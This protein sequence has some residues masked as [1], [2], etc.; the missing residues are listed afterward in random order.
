L[1]TTAT[2]PFACH[3]HQNTQQ[4]ALSGLTDRAGGTVTPRGVA[5]I[6]GIAAGAN[7][8]LLLHR[9]GQLYSWGLGVSGRLGLDVAIGGH[10]QVR[11]A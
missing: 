2:P 6:V 1:F 4:L 9:S 7:H 5:A 8:S 11:D 3:Q 10:P